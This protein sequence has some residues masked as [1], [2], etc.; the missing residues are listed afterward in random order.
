MMN[1]R[2]DFE[3]GRL[4]HDLGN[5]LLEG[6]PGEFHPNYYLDKVRSYLSRNQPQASFEVRCTD[7]MGQVWG[8][9]YSQPGL[10]PMLPAAVRT[11]NM[12]ISKVHVTPKRKSRYH[13][14]P[15]I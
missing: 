12:S 4:W 3:E 14:E 10:N 8:L 9:R 7:L 1:M 15:V 6:A 13:R 2:T 11:F 5:V